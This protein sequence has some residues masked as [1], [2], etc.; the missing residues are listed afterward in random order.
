MPPEIV[1]RLAV[2]SLASLQEPTAHE[3]F[4]SQTW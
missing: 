4:A 3:A 2:A 1:E